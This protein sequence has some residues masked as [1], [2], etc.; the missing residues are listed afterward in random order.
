ML[1]KLV[2]EMVQAVEDVVQ[3]E[4]HFILEI[5]DNGFSSLAMRACV[6]LRSRRVLS[7][8]RLIKRDEGSDCWD[9]SFYNL[10]LLVQV[11]V[12]AED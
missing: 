3:H 6:N 12:A 11:C 10:M 1:W 2:Y 7:P 8:K 5:V 9:L 4:P